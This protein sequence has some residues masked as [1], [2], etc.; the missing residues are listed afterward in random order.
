[1]NN[2]IELK[3]SY[4]KS[5]E[6]NLPG[7]KSISN[8]VLLLSS[9]ANGNTVIKNFLFSDDTEV[10]ISAL[11]TLG[12]NIKENK[13]L[14][15][16]IISGSINSF[17]VKNADLYI[18]N[19]G[20]AIRPLTAA[21]A[22]NNGDYKLYGTKRM[23]E[24]PIKDLIDSLNSIGANIKYLNEY[25]YPPIQI[26]KT[27]HN[28][29][30]VI[31]KGN[32][33]SQ[34]LTSLILSSTIFSKNKDFKIYVEG[35]LISKPYINITLKLMNLFGVRILEK[36]NKVFL[37][38]SKQILNSPKKIDIES[39]ASSASYFLAAA[40]IGGGALK[41]NGLGSKSI[42]G[43]IQFIKILEK[44]GATIKVKNDFI[45]VSCDKVL[46]SINEDLNH[47]P[48]AAM[49]LAILALYADG[50]SVL[51]NIGSWRVKETDRLKAMSTELRKVGAKIIEGKDFLQI[52]PPL[53]I[54]N[55]SIDTYDDHRMAMCFSLVS[56]NSYSKKGGIIKINDSNCVSKTF[57]DY[58]DYFK[59]ILK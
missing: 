31:V 40:A 34:F 36:K 16:C 25:G 4:L 9:L 47:I 58:F 59:K 41:I 3:P 14:S 12:I 53:K 23:H 30:K 27:N 22:F 17:P 7:S 1:M 5:G 56:L 8:R 10:M 39:D 6:L 11:K 32:V 18:G 45:E 21:L 13:K 15:E 43:D 51:K 26:K 42:Q 29:N 55:A 46:K 28:T 20:T 24:R 38:S 57:P 50:I 52:E 44:M 2:F 37:I 48:D 49:T 35:N 54:K 19:A 33:S